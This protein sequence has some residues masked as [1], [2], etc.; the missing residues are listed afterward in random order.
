MTISPS[1]SALR[2]MKSDLGSAGAVGGFEGSGEEGE[3]RQREIARAGTC[4]A[5]E[6][7]GHDR[8]RGIAR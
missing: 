2:F 6:T 4:R 8:G 5:A 7:G 3:K 1:A